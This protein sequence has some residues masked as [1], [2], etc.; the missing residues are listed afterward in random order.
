MTES[1]NKTV[2]H[3]TDKYYDMNQVRFIWLINTS[4]YLWSDDLRERSYDEDTELTSQG[5]VDYI[6]KWPTESE[7]QAKETP[8][9]DTW[10]RGPYLVLKQPNEYRDEAILD[11]DPSL[12]RYFS[13][14]APTRKGI[15]DFA[16]KYGE[17]R[18]TIEL[19]VS[20][21][22][23]NQDAITVFQSYPLKNGT[24][25]ILPA[26]SFVF[27]KESIQE[28]KW[29][30]QLWDWIKQEDAT[31]LGKVITSDNDRFILADIEVTEQYQDADAVVEASSRGNFDYI[32]GFTGD[33]AFVG[34]PDYSPSLF[35][36]AKE[37]I[38]DKVY[39][40]L[41][42]KTNN[43]LV[44]D[45]NRNLIPYLIPDDL[46]TAMWIQFYLE[47]SGQTSFKMCGICGL[48]EDVTNKNKNW[49]VHPPCA[50]RR[51]VDKYQAKIKQAHAEER[52]TKPAKKPAAK[53]PTKK[54]TAKKR[55]ERNEPDSQEGVSRR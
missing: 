32:D 33:I 1:V 8:D 48:W 23:I 49:K 29:M 18:A 36:L 12:Y 9:Y 11:K 47:V 44:F 27:W 40:M 4:G 17:L 46:L 31:S 30:L 35:D 13:L 54:A 45:E 42:G 24:A 34:E 15:L 7:R 5:Q 55:G 2:N 22:K 53:K 41:Q 25:Y 52:V 20:T 39:Y 43:C 26:D 3:T 21:K 28:M 10:P 37:V 14:V 6:M 38:R 51:R 16:N 19:L 50:A